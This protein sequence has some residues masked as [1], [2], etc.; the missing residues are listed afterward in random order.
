MP[1]ILKWLT[2][3]G[4]VPVL[5]VLGT[6]IPNGSV[7]VNGKPM[8]NSLWWSCGAGGTVAFLAIVMTVATTL[9][10]QR[11]RYARPVFLAGMALTAMSGLLINKFTESNGVLLL[12]PVVGNLAIVGVVAMYLYVSKAVSKYFKTGSTSEL[13]FA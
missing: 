10:I 7:N 4:L 6:L 13:P 8:A 12:W 2:A 3:V 11:S 9:I 1:G 5:F